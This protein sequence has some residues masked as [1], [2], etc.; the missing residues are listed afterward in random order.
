MPRFISYNSG[1]FRGT[2]RSTTNNRFRA[3]IVAKLPLPKHLIVIPFSFGL[4]SGSDGSY[5]QNLIF[6]VPRSRLDKMRLISVNTLEMRKLFDDEIPNMSS[7]RTHGRK[8]RSRTRIGRPSPSFP[9][10]SR[11][12]QKWVPP[13]PKSKLSSSSAELNVSKL[14][15]DHPPRRCPKLGPR[16][17]FGPG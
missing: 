17:C 5:T 10:T 15:L 4:Q 8:G 6:T 9:T 1:C 3:P 12:A 7:C 13:L 14:S 11:S 2:W 16:P